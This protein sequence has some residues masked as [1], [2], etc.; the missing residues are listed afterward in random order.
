MSTS[1][2]R[3]ILGALVGFA[4]LGAGCAGER[5]PID[6]VQPDAIPKSFLIGQKLN[7]PTDDPEFYSRSMLVGVDYGSSGGGL[8]SAGYNTVS[9]IRWSVEQNFLLGRLAYSRIKG[10]NDQG[11]KKDIAEDPRDQKTNDGEVVYNFPITSHFDIRRD[12]NPATGEENNV[13]VE[14]TTD[15]P[16][17]DREYIRVDWTQNLNTAGYK[18]DT[19]AFLNLIG[20]EYTNSNFTANNPNFEDRPTY[21]FDNRYNYAT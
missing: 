3:I 6:R 5:D 4:S 18:L 17:Y 7:D 15:R 16:W 9:R 11:A 1:L 20:V 12:F 21:K 10:A 19:I 2:N 14:N 13:R 8:F